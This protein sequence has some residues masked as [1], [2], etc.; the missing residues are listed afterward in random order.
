VEQ[1]RGDD[2][3]RDSWSP[4]VI[5]SS[6]IGLYQ[7]DSLFSNNGRSKVKAAASKPR[8]PAVRTAGV[9]CYVVIRDDVTI[10]IEIEL[11]DVLS[12][13]INNKYTNSFIHPLVIIG[14]KMQYLQ[15]LYTEKAG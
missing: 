11:L 7:E 15:D 13:S 9:N 14:S 2:Q 1:G 8:L 6:I 12:C 4:G 5:L 10:L 3:K